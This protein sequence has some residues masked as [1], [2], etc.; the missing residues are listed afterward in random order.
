MRSQCCLFV[1]AGYLLA[2]VATR[3]TRTSLRSGVRVDFT[4]LIPGLIEQAERAC[5]LPLLR[6]N[7]YDAARN[8]LPDRD[9]EAIGSLSRVKVRLGRIGFNGEQKGVDLRIGLDMVAQARNGAVDVIFLVS[10]D[11]DLSE[12]VEEAQAHGVLVK[13][14][15]VPDSDGAAHAVSEHLL[16]ASD[17]IELVDSEILDRTVV[18][19]VV[20]PTPATI[21]RPGPRPSAVPGGPGMAAGKAESVMRLPLRPGGPFAPGVG[22]GPLPRPAESTLAYRSETGAKSTMGAEYAL[23]DADVVEAIR[24]VI[25]GVIDSFLASAADEERAEVLSAEPYIRPDLDRALLLDLAHRLTSLDLSDHIRY[26][27]R[28][29]FWEALKQSV[30]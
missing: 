23:E 1:D 7:W 30:G 24:H 17:G 28:S 22:R 15:A 10:G 11:D 29:Q 5:Q 2:S 16:R 12:A 9:Q 13:I 19:V 20:K 3:L 27:L 18:R 14:L 6:I 21:P 4:E 8:A 26:A 25:S